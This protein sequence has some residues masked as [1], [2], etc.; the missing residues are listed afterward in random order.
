[1]KKIILLLAISAFSTMA[2]ANDCTGT[3][4]GAVRS[5]VTKNAKTNKNWNESITSAEQEP[6]KATEYSRTYKIYTLTGP[7]TDPERLVLVWEVETTLDC[8]IT[9]IEFLG[10]VE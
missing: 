8:K 2:Y 7:S 3:A 5:V 10:G 6:E 4:K 9:K 1:M